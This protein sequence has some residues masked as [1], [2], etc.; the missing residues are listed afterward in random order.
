MCTSAA[1]PACTVRKTVYIETKQNKKWKKKIYVFEE[2]LV[3]S[4]L[5]LFV[6]F[7]NR[8]VTV[9]ILRIIPNF[10]LVLTEKKTKH[11]K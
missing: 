10:C 7:L 4:S 5:T 11:D 2:Y 3:F 9:K 1:Y 8:F 6:S